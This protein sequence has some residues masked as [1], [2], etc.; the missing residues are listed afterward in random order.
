MIRKLLWLLPGALIALLMFLP[1]SWLGPRLVPA[2][3]AS[4][5]T[6]YRGTIWN[7]VISD[8]KDVRSVEYIASPLKLLSAKPPIK[9]RVTATG[10]QANA[11]LGRTKAQDVSLQINVANLPL[12]DPRLKGLS[13]QITARIESVEWAKNGQCLTMRGTASSDVLT[14]NQRL[15]AWSGPVV[16]GPVSCDDGGVYVFNLSG[17]DA[18]QKI[19]AIV[20]ISASGDYRSD[21]TVTTRDSDAVL[22]LPLFGFEDRGQ[23]ADGQEFR[24]VEQGKWR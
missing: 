7:G 8:L 24:L 15:F 18:V 19:D 13:G 22:V 16:A 2:E 12:P 3:L 20:S 17:N 21:M 4:D 11:D 10:L 23:K 14:K 9:A 1:L 6:T 5:K